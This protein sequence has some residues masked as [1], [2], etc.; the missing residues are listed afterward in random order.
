MDKNDEGAPIPLPHHQCSVADAPAAGEIVSPSALRSA[1]GRTIESATAIK[2][3][4]DLGHD[5]DN[6]PRSSTAR[7][8]RVRRCRRRR[9]AGRSIHGV[10]LRSRRGHLRSTRSPRPP[11][12][13]RR[14]ARARRER[15]DPTRLRAL[16]RSSTGSDACST[17]LGLDSANVRPGTR[18]ARLISGGCAVSSAA[19]RA[20]SRAAQRRSTAG[21]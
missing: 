8:C 15:A 16:P 18:W 11:R 21:T 12:D 9:G 17:S 3:S 4:K 20:S 10:G 7:G 6:P 14:S 13:R 2:T 19:T 1:A 5:V